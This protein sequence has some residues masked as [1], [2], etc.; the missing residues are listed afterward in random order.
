MGCWKWVFRGASCP[1]EPRP[2]VPS[3]SRLWLPAG[4]AGR[5]VPVPAEVDA[6][7]PAEMDAPVP[8]EMD[9]LLWGCLGSPPPGLQQSLPPRPASGSG[10][11]KPSRSSASPALGDLRRTFSIA[12]VTIKLAVRISPWVKLISLQRTAETSRARL[13]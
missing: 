7:V 3:G 10:A 4:R 1:A 11:L 5:T 12:A 13:R 2:A 9:A 6:P 8:P